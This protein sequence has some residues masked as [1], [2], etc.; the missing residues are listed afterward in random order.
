MTKNIAIALSGGIDSLVAAY[1]LRE[2]GYRLTGIHFL[3]G[4]EPEN[5]QKIGNISQQLDITLEIVDCSSAF[6]SV[7]V[8]YFIQTY[9]HGQT[10]NP[11]LVC[12]PGV[13]F[14][15][16]L[17][18]ARKTGVSALGTGHYARVTKDEAGRFRLF[19][20]ADPKKDQ[21]YFLAFLTQRQL[22]QACFPLGNMSKSE[23]R[24]LAA[25]KG[26]CPAVKEES[27][28]ICFIRGMG[29][30]EFL[31]RHGGFRPK[32]GPI[33]DM[34]GR[35]IGEHKGLHLFT[36]GQ[37]RGI[38]CPGPEPYYV[39]RLDLGKNRLTVGFKND[40]LSGECKVAGINWIVQPPSS[41]IKIFTR[42]RYRHNAA[43]SVLFP[44]DRHMAVVKFEENQAA[45]TP[46]QG[47]VFYREDEVVGGGWIVKG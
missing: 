13:K 23:V 15:T 30:G 33:E 5:R 6:K 31:V 24:E 47:A 46:G 9:R 16:V 1:L 10:P 8:D 20:G 12:N 19:K 4:Y 18:F 36:I 44:I 40:L 3:T 28:D 7:V 37:R 11:C 2:K 41:P 22:A 25:E 21:S 38:N 27:Q 39:V 17:D 35:I 43:L 32:P 29:Y 45:I 34:S 42:V 14:G 26:L